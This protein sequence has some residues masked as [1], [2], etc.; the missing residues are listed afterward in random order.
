MMVFIHPIAIRRSTAMSTELNR[1]II[2]RW[3]E[4]GWNGRNLDLIDQ[5][6]SPDVI[7]HDPNSPLAVRSSGEMRM[8]IGGFQSAFPDLHFTTDDLL[9]EG[10]KVLWRF[11]SRGTHHGALMGIPP[12]GKALTVVGMALF[13]IAEGRIAEVWVNIDAL[14]ML[15]SLGVIPVMG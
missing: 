11:T 1:S 5:L 6:Y 9:A 2:R 4:E 14:G 8:Y 13:R 15:Q 7:Q 12:T 10:D 3:I